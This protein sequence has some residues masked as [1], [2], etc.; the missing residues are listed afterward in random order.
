MNRPAIITDTET[1]ARFSAEEFMAMASGALGEIVGKV[2]LVDGVIVRMAPA[3]YPHFAYQREL[4]IKLHEIFGTGI[5]GFIVG[6]ELTVRLG[7]AT[8]RDPN[9][10]IFKEPGM[11]PGIVAWDVL[12]LAA[13]ISDSTL[14][15]DMGPK[16][17]SYAQ[18]GVPDYWVVDING[19]TVHRFSRIVDG[20]YAD[21]DPVA[22]GAPIAVPGTDRAITID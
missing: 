10:A 6:Q 17:L 15:D 22:F 14:R 12:L 13:E 3:N 19:R 2:E 11:I 4:F 20:D 9:I 8:V 1:L 7:E 18:A 16:R 21:D 5:D